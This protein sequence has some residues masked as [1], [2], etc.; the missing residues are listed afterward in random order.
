MA[1]LIDIDTI[2][3]YVCNSNET[4]AE[5]SSLFEQHMRLTAK[6]TAEKEGLFP[7]IE[8]IW[9][10]VHSNVA[11]MPPNWF[12]TTA[13]HKMHDSEL[14][15]P[16]VEV[17]KQNIIPM[18]NEIARLKCLIGQKVGGSASL[19]GPFYINL[20]K[21]NKDFDEWC[22]EQNDDEYGVDEFSHMMKVEA[23]RI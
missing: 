3:A 13:D 21:E 4:T 15:L 5:N 19:H 7:Q 22:E 1:S 10:L 17:W 18:E 16:L 20:C 6:L 14:F 11:G 23:A 12:P 9:D 8:F 2:V